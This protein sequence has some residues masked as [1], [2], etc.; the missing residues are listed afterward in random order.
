[1]IPAC[2]GEL[3]RRLRLFE[4]LQHE[5]A[6]PRWLLGLDGVYDALMCIDDFLNLAESRSAA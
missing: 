5:L 4:V 2:R 6:R 1:M 3:E